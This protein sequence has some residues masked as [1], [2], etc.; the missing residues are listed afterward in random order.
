MR[1][2][3]IA[4][5]FLL[6]WGCGKN[7][8]YH[9]KNNHDWEEFFFDKDYLSVNGQEFCP[10]NGADQARHILFSRHDGRR[11][12]ASFQFMTG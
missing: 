7:V 4:I 2:V 5:V 3:W 12:K 8:N 9:S 6:T 10:R 1:W 11:A